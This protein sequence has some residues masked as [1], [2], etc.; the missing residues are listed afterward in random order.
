MVYLVT[1]LKRNRKMNGD[2]LEVSK[3]GL[4]IQN[5]TFYNCLIRSET[6]WS[7]D[8]VCENS[9]FENCVF[10]GVIPKF[11]ENCYIK[12]NIYPDNYDEESILDDVCVNDLPEGDLI[13]YK[14]VYTF[15]IIKGIFGNTT[16]SK[17]YICKLL[18]PSDAK[19]SRG[20]SRKCRAS[21]AK[22]LGF[23]SLNKKPVNIKKAFSHYDREFTYEVGAIVR[24]KKKFC[25]NP[26]DVCSSGIHF[27][28]RF[29]EAAE[30]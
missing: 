28:T 17:A 9:R 16:N 4:V 12:N 11:D 30:Y 26:L 8:I 13:V 10:I 25:D 7:L 22:V 21:K 20:V 6:G 2:I 27:F 23:Y 3:D 14:K 5:E 24:P 19:R 29:K 15:K 18:V 1:L